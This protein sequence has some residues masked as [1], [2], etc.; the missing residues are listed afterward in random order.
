MAAFGLLFMLAVVVTSPSQPARAPERADVG[1]AQEVTDTVRTPS[2]EPVEPSG[3]A[4]APKQATTV[5]GAAALA[6][7]V[8]LAFSRHKRQG[9]DRL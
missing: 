9:S 8:G 4:D 6:A 1:I 5:I 2:A 7:V 3:D